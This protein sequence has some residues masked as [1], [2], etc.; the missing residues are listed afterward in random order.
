MVSKMS[1]QTEQHPPQQP[2]CPTCGG[3]GQLNFFKGE[4]R[5]LLSA[6]ECPSCCGFGYV[7]EDEDRLAKD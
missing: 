2:P 4:S 5:F 7:Q 1:E 3:T 6:E